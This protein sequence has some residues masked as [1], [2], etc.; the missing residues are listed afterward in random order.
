MPGGS[1]QGRS[2]QILTYRFEPGRCPASPIGGLQP[3]APLT[4]AAGQH[5][6][7]RAR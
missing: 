4:C 5:R 6:P 2:R 3:Q 1:G 7:V